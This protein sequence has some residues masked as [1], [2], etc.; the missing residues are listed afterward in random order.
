MSRR[1]Q[2][3]PLALLLA[4]LVA[5]AGLL[6][7]FAGRAGPDGRIDVSAPSPADTTARAAELPIETD[8]VPPPRV[9]VQ[10]G[11]TQT[12]VLWPLRV[13]LDLLRADYLPTERGVLPI[14]SGANAR[15]AGRIADDSG[16]VRARVEFVSGPNEG[17]VLHTDATGAFGASDLYAGLSI[18]EVRGE[19]IAGSR[20]EV[21]LRQGR[22]TLLNIGYGRP[23]SVMGRVLDREGNPI[24]NAQVTFD[25]TRVYTDAAGEFYLASVASGQVLVEIEKEGFASYQELASVTAGQ[26]T[27]RERLTFTLDRPASLTLW[28]PQDIGG[29]GPVLVYLL[30]GSADRRP[31]IN[32]AHRSGR[33]PWHQVNP[34]EVLPGQAKTVDALPAEL[35]KVFAFRP[36]AKARTRSVR[37]RRGEPQQVEIDLRPAARLVGHVTRDGQPVSGA[38]VR[39]E[40]PNRTRAALAFFD[41]PSWFFETEVIPFV[42]PAVQQTVTDSSGRFLLTAWEEVA[43]VR[44]LEARGPDGSWAGRLVRT[45]ETDVD[46][47]LESVDLADAE[48]VLTLAGRRQGLPVELLID[49]QPYDPFV[50]PPNEPLLIED[51]VPGIWNLRVSWHG[52][53]LDSAEELRI[54]GITERAVRLIPDAIEGQPEEAWTRAGREFPLN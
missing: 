43:D 30:P 52:I 11:D 10:A 50:L 5:G 2:A 48:L 42:E 39:L 40:A 29:P 38:S 19:R 4:M 37:L 44:Y 22:E 15:L 36:G 46:L 25:G 53:A 47:E 9:P 28:V 16:G 41:E 24:E 3:A 54:D 13:E 33:Y 32:E 12:T 49:G 21:R 1:N 23:G 8:L 20:R 35:V 51:L 6:A 17:R 18:V 14:G 26:L 31:S 34:I 27:Q 45:G 7:W